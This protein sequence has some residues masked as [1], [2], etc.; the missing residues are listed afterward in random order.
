MLCATNV[1]RKMSRNNSRWTWMLSERLSWRNRVLLDNPSQK[2]TFILGIECVCKYV[3]QDSWVLTEFRSRNLLLSQSCKL[4][5]NLAPAKRK[6]NL[7]VRSRVWEIFRGISAMLSN[8]ARATPLTITIREPWLSLSYDETST[9]I[10][11][12]FFLQAPKRCLCACVKETLVTSFVHADVTC[13][14]T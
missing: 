3:Y 11:L 7:N 8:N 4:S 9:W 1:V 2:L 12:I 13:H 6:R 14:H 5:S 10:S